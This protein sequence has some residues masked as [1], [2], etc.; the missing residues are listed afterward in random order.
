MASSNMT[1]SRFRPLTVRAYFAI[2]A[3][4][5][6]A[7]PAG[8][9]PPPGAATDAPNVT[10]TTTGL[11]DADRPAAAAE[12]A[13][14]PAGAAPST[15]GAGGGVKLSGRVTFDGT[16]PER[17]PI[18]MSKEA[19]CIEL[20]GGKQV[21]DEAVL[22]GDD[23][24]VKNAFVYI[25]RGAPKREY[26]VP[27]EPAKLEQKDCMYRPRVQ[28]IFVGQRLLV[29]NND[30]VTHNV[31]SFPIR[32]RPFNFGQPPDSEP[33]ERVFEAAEREIEVQCDI[34]PWMHAYLFVMDHPFFCVT[35]D[36]GSY[37]IDAL[38]PGEYTV[39]VWH[40][41]FGR[42]RQTVTVGDGDMQDVN[43]TYKP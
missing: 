42:Q 5:L 15:D 37:T 4:L 40:E 20:H 21:L 31:R 29:G 39:E 11:R 2:L 27:E 22:V 6:F 18:N 26:P 16:P 7:L 32:S 23:G 19:K 12:A 34:H 3:A 43:F 10:T 8:C 24:G 30:P 1:D 41:K 14:K 38:P 9:E 28:G 13:G 25:R 33:R 17:R 36:H 35:D